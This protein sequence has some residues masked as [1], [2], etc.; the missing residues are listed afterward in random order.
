MPK[1]IVVNLMVAGSRDA[2]ATYAISVAKTFDAYLAGVAFAYEPVL[3]AIVGGGIPE[4]VIEEQREENEK[5]AKTA[6][7]Q[8]EAAA[9][10]VKHESRMVPASLAGAADTFGEIARVFDLAIVGQ[11]ERDRVGPE[12]LIVEGAL[13]GSGRPILVVPADYQGGM[14]LERVLICWN[15]GRNAARATANSIPFLRRANTVEIVTVGTEAAAAAETSAADLA[16]HLGRHEIKATVKRIEPGNLKVS[17]A[18]LDY[19]GK[20]GAGMLVMGGYGHSRLREFI[21]G[22]TTRGVLAAMT[23]PTLMSH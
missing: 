7:T 13:F 10:D 15:G 17:A 1:D 19:A 14:R 3:P 8:F 21:L 11:S 22:G 9:K 23:V 16:R 12:E 4:S 5:A 6:V 18:I 20:S 2:A